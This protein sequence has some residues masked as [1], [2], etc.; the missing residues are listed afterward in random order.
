MNPTR[1][2]FELALRSDVVRRSA[3]VAVIVGTLLTLINY[4]D[5]FV[6]GRF[7]FAQWWRIVLTYCVPYGVSTYAGVAALR[8]R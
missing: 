4:G 8:E 6:T 3:K 2:W 1:Q 5:L 7:D